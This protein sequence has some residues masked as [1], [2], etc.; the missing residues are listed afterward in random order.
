MTH[1]IHHVA[2]RTL[3]R[4][5]HCMSGC[6]AMFLLASLVFIAYPQLDLWVSDLFY[7]DHGNFPA[8]D[9]WPI[10][11]IYHGTPW[12]GRLLFVCS[13]ALLLLAVMM[14][15]K[16]SRRNWRRACALVAVVVLGIGLLVHTVL[17]D[18]MGR[19]RPRDVQVFAG[20][21]AFVPVF[22]PSQF[23]QTNCSFVSGHAAVGFALMSFGMFGTR[24][25]RQ[26]WLFTGML[27]GGLI[28]LARIAQ[29][30]HFLSDIVFSLIAIWSSHLLIRAVWL[31]FRGW[32][33]H[34]RAIPISQMQQSL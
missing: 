20:P 17:K 4:N 15:S 8:N 30:G 22:V 1:P 33:I 26:F 34:R 23:C 29:G 13:I 32:Q 21:A 31:R 14:P 10:K 6:F 24:R 2:K 19:P 9:L 27:A 5:F 7:A 18:G 3:T 12:A 16:V 25:K 11:G 28:G